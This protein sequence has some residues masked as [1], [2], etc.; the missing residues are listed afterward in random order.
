MVID[1]HLHTTRY[2]TS[3][4]VLDPRKMLLRLRDLGLD[5]GAVTEHN[6]LWTEDELARL[7]DDTG[8][9]DLFLVSGKEV[10][11][12]VGHVLLFGFAGGIAPLTPVREIIQ[13]VHD[14]GGITVWAHPLRYGQY[15]QVSDDRIIETAGLFDAVEALTPSHSPSENDR[16]LALSRRHGLTATGGSDAHTSNAVGRCLTRFDRPLKNL[17]DLIAAVKEGACRPVEGRSW[18]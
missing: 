6:Y 2:S 1:L 4:S 9:E 11:S 17:A 14:V 3:C 12:D 18:K 15:D 16:M 10:D 8:T 5:G 13:R 7:K